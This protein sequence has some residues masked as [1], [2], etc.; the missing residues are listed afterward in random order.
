MK[1]PKSREAARAALKV[2]RTI[3]IAGY[4]IPAVLVFLII[5]G[6]LFLW[7][8]SI[9]TGLTAI[10]LTPAPG[11]LLMIWII[12]W[13]KMFERKETFLRDYLHNH[14]EDKE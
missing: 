12:I 5:G 2:N 1:E 7:Q 14:K 10:K 13:G 11:V 8:K 6:I 4:V 3:H 9:I